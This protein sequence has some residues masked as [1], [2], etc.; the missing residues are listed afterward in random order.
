MQ[1]AEDNGVKRAFSLSDPNMVRFCAEGLSR[2][3]G[4]GVDLLFCNRE[5]ALGFAQCDNLDEAIGVLKQWTKTLVVTLG[6][7][8][9]LI[10]DFENAQPIRIEGVQVAA[11]DTNG[12]GDLFAGSFLHGLN[13]GLSLDKAGQLAAYASAQ[14]VTEFGPRLKDEKLAKVKNFAAKLGA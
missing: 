6:A 4:R 13:N 9:A 5:E 11:V 1:V 14:L 7:E 2:I 12:A 3:I 8:G 10:V